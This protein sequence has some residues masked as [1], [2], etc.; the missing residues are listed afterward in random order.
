MKLEQNYRSVGN[1]LAAANAVIANN[2][3]R[4]AKKLF[5]SAEDGD[6]I[7]VYMAADERDE[8]RWIA[9]AKL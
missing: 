2:Q 6:K 4:K 1:V 5:T 9:A 3:H 7:Q 8:G